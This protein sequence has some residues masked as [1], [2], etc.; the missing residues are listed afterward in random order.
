MTVADLHTLTG[1]YAVGALPAGEAADFERHV[2]RCEACAREVRELRETAA[3]LALA[4]AEVPP[5]GLR[6]RVLAALPDVRQLPPRTRRRPAAAGDRRWRPRLPYLAA[7]ACL[8]VAAV[9][10]GVA[11]DARHDAAA[12]RG[13]TAAAEAGSRA[14]GAVAAAPDAAFHTR[15]LTGG[16]TATVV[17]S[18]RLGRTAVLFHGLP[19][20]PGSRVYELWYSRDA[21]MVPAGL[22]DPADPSAALLLTGGPAGAEAVGVTVEP[23]G[24]SATP[25]GTP[26]AVVPL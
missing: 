3:R 9:A 13:R 19:K 17:F 2:A 22:L 7:A 11:V 8:A 5:A 16:G 6:V 20:L 12:Q 21:T 14:V 18:V 1:A 4:V 26:L 10:A 25:T 15:A 24:G 23:H